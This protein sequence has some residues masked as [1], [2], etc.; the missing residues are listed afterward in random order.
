MIRKTGYLLTLFLLLAGKTVL[1]QVNDAQLWSSVNLE[2]KLTPA[3]SIL[4]TE[5]VRIIENMTEVETIFSELGVSYMFWKRL[6][7][8]GAYR[9]T[10][11][12]RLDDTYEKRNSWYVEGSYH[13]KIKPFRLVFRVRYQSRY[14]EAFTSEKSGT[15]K[16]HL[17]TKLMVKYDLSKKTEPYV[18]A[19][20]FF[21]TGVPAAESF[22]ELRL[23]AGVKYAFNRMH[24]VDLHYL[25]CK[26]YN[27]AN[28][29]TA[30]VIGAGYYFIF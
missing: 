21:K 16:N 10:L 13:E 7:L 12:R 1:A 20:T 11:K 22:D 29:E 26:E 17:R 30:Y 19:E 24:K 9:F 28:P 25:F 4:F 3:L 27:A 5:E 6:K 23:C 8:E 18:Y 14:A 2:K 15:P